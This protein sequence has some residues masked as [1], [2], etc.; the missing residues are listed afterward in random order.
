[1]VRQSI[2]SRDCMFAKRIKLD[3][4]FWNKKVFRSEEIADNDM[5]IVYS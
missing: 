1:M 3:F 2:F 4:Q 5:N